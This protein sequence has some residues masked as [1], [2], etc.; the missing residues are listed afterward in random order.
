M[1][2]F[3]LRS[4]VKIRDV[5]EDYSVWA[6]WELNNESDIGQR[7]WRHSE[8]SGVAEPVWPEGAPSP[9]ILDSST[10]SLRDMRAPGMGSR[11]LV[12]TGD[13]R[14]FCSPRLITT[15]L[16][17]S[18]QAQQA[19]DHDEVDW[20]AYVS[21]RIT[22]GVPEGFDDIGPSSA[23]PMESNLDFMGGR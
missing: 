22:Q 2:R 7:H 1:K 20:K 14:E 15:P 18:L 19:A 16:I 6:H 9:W 17:I 10:P 4:K 8:F 12:R 5:T 23:L 13:R 11:S 3:V 21:H